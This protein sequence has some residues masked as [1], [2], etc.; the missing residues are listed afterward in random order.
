M[1]ALTK[2][3]HPTILNEI[4][5]KIKISTYLNRVGIYATKYKFNDFINK[6][7]FTSF[8]HLI[9]KLKMPDYKYGHY[10]YATINKNTATIYNS[11]NKDPLYTATIRLGDEI[12]FPI[13]GD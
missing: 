7:N 4:T 8:L 5:H 9:L 3:I 12:S 11:W 6:L 13:A 10:C 2:I 1:I